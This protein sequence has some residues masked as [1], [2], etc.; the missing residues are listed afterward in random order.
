MI[1][2][3]KE[4]ERAQ[5]LIKKCQS[6]LDDA[7]EKYAKNIKIGTMIEIPSAAI[8][9][10]EISE[11]CDFLSIGTN[12]LVQ[13]TLAVDRNNDLVG[14]YYNE[15]DPAVL[16]LIK[17][18]CQ[19]AHAHGIKVAVCG[20]MA[21]QEKFTGLLIGLGVDELSTSPNNYGVVK[22]A[23]LGLDSKESQE[24]ADSLLI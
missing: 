5:R 7:G 3:V 4:I 17:Q 6:E 21:A 18:V 1:S 19:A 16:T 8:R 23:I 10:S 15:T 24:Y 9:A 14:E 22:K 20:E 2:S 12:D 11:A 13:Y